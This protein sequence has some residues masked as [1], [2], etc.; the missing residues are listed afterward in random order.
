MKLKDPFHLT[1]CTNIHPG[2]TFAE[3]LKAL[4]DNLPEVR[5]QVAGAGQH[6]FGIGLRLSDQASTELQAPDNMRLLKDWLQE[7]NCYV[8]TMNGFP[9]GGF[10]RQRVKDEVHQP[11]WTTPQRLAYT[12]RLFEQ[13]AELLPEAQTGGIS[14]SPLT[15][16]HWFT[17]S[18]QQQVKEKAAEQLASIA[19]QLFEL[20]DN[21]GKNLHL[22]IEPEPD[23]LLE[24]GPEF[25]EYFEDFLLLHGRKMLQKQSGFGAARAEEIIRNHIQLCY[26]VCHFAVGY[27]DHQQVFEAYQRAEVQIGKI[28]ISAALKME[29]TGNAADRKQIARELSPF[30]ES[31]YLHQVVQ[32][33]R[34][35]S[36]KRYRDLPQALE[37]L[38]REQE[39]AEWR[40]HF[41]VPVFLEDYGLLQSTQ[42]DIVTVLGLMKQFPVAHLEVETY[43]W[44][45]LPPEIRL[46][47]PDSIAREL[48]WVKEKLA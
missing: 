23:G 43:T 10:H 48:N 1:Y 16:R 27:E 4:Q 25:L 5:A 37:A 18:E 19:W 20:A 33:Q 7:Q 24:T 42:A 32:K 17:T 36:L 9:F 3:V 28:Q 8:F 38:P 12:R 6:P 41:H 15:Y 21:R 40:T 26:D 39:A 30:N 22:D 46:P 11:D 13:L 2:E 45:V 14:T 34:N 35:G 29:I 47:L 31:T 44:E